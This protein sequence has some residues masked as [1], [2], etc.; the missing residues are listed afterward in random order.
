MA[1]YV[2]FFRFEACCHDFYICRA[3]SKDPEL[4]RTYLGLLKETSIHEKA[5]VR[6]LGR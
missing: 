3:A 4:E 5:I 2:S 6:D 1:T